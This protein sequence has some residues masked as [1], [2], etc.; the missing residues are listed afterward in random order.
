MKGIFKPGPMFPKALR[1]WIVVCCFVLAG[2]CGTC[3]PAYA[4]APECPADRVCISR[5]AALKAIADGDAVKAD[6]VAIDGYKQAIEDL[7]ADLNKLRVSFA[8][9]SGKLS[10]ADQAAVRSDAIIDLLLKNTK[11]KCMPFSFCLN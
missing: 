5:E 2:V 11:K 3:Q 4:Q 8:E 1:P 9:V 10:G 6:K 7:R